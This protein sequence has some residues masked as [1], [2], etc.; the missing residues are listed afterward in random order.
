M[1]LIRIHQNTPNKEKDNRE[2]KTA[3]QFPKAILG[4][5]LIPPRPNYSS[6]PNNKKIYNKKNMQP[7]HTRA[8]RSKNKK[9]KGVEE[10]NRINTHKRK[11]IN[12]QER[13][14]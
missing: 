3:L 10:I 13:E 1:L 5:V 12:T 6:R 14:K 8:I 9:N 4:L 2:N 11:K 7:A